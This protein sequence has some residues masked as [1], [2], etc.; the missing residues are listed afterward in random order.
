MAKDLYA[1][2]GVPR[3]ANE[4]QIKKAFRK[5]AMKYHPDKNPGKANEQRFKEVNRAHE[6]LSD[7]KKRALYDEFGEESLSQGFDPDRARVIRQ[8]G[9]MPRG[10]RRA[11]GVPGGVDVQEIFG[12]SGD[13]GDMF[14][15]LFG[16]RGARGPRGP[17]RGQDM[18]TSV[19]IDFVSAVKGTQLQLQRGDQ[20]VTV[21]IPPGANEGSR[22]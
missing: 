9:G 14:G 7:E 4:D 18:E 1:V 17:M 8:Y 5:L 21:R 3:D 20:T 19:T 13:F 12:G 6:V 15:D 22:V 2:L 11:G 10:G 16:R